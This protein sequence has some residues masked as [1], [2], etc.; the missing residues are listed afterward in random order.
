MPKNVKKP[1]PYLQPKN[2][3]VEALAN[4]VGTPLPVPLR[5]LVQEA[6][7]GLNG[8][9]AIPSIIIQSAVEKAYAL[10]VEAKSKP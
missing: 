7:N 6:L 4:R 9:T 1:N 2:K 10:G 5:K 8:P 3:R